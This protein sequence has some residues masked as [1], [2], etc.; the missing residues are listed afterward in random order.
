MMAQAE[1]PEED[2][3]DG[4]L[5]TLVRLIGAS[6]SRTGIVTP[7]KYSH[8]AA[9]SAQLVRRGWRS[10]DPAENDEDKH[11]EVKVDILTSSR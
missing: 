3:E 4:G 9:G 10:R 2:G 5:R 7:R 6:S 11:L 8:C 1:D